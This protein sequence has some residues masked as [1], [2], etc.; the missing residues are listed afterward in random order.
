MLL[1]GLW[2]GLLSSTLES[3]GAESNSLAK[4]LPPVF[5]IVSAR[6]RKGLTEAKG[7]Y[8]VYGDVEWK[9]RVEG[10][11]WFLRM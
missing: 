7:Q 4:C 1:S 5:S 8:S 9:G 2:K 11:S 6:L 10:S 3:V